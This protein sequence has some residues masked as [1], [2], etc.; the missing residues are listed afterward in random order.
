M[1]VR[2]YLGTTL[3]NGVLCIC[4][5]VD[6]KIAY[7]YTM[8]KNETECSLTLAM[9]VLEK[10]GQ[11]AQIVVNSCNEKILHIPKAKQ[12]VTVQHCQHLLINK[13]YQLSYQHVSSLKLDT[14][15]IINL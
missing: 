12:V 11:D 8:T 15:M 2:A 7:L 14:L 10:I 6:G 5:L 9:Q 13:S 1:T 4:W 3:Q